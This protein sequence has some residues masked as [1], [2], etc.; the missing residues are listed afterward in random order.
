MLQGALLLGLGWLEMDQSLTDLENHI[1]NITSSV[2]KGE[3]K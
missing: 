2:A 1:P 3:N